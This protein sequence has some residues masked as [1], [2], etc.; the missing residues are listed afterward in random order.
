MRTE[1]KRFE[2]IDFVKYPP[3][4]NKFEIILGDYE[5]IQENG[6]C[7]AVKKSKYPKTYEEC[8]AVLPYNENLR[9]YPSFRQGI[10]E[11]NIKLFEQLDNL[12]KLIICRD[13]YWKI[14]GEQMGLGKPWQ[15]DWLNVEQDK[16]VLFT[17]N[18][19]ICS[20][21]Y[22]LGHNILAFPT[23][24]MRDV[25]YENFKDLIEQC[26]ELL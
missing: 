10:S 12:R 22:V 13:T 15:P 8:C 19:A 6:K 7:Y 18:N 23:E 17:H 5:I 1:E 14:A 25:F 2:C 11:H 24:E 26:K 21:C 9:I 20:N 3:N 4:T 16:Y